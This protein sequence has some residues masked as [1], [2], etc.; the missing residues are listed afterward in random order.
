[1]P[2]L[3]SNALTVIGSTPDLLE[4][5]KAARSQDVDEHTG[6]R[7]VVGFERH[8]PLPPN[9]SNDGKPRPGELFPDWYLWR[10][11][12]WGTKWNADHPTRRGSAKRG[13][14]VYRFLTAFAPPLPWLEVVAK[15]HPS[16]TF[17]LEFQEEFDHFSGFERWEGGK[18]V[19]DETRS[20][21]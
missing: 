2:N 8:V 20:L 18:F 12:H 17:E 4:F 11:K 5:M 19:A 3:C 14:L 13:C 16:L 9:L 15:A 10:T 1:M 7:F 21:L 6:K